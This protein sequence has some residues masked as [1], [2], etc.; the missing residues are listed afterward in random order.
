MTR[1]DPAS[2]SPSN[3]PAPTPAERAALDAARERAIKL[4]TD[5][6]ADDT[7]TVEEFE[8]RLDRMYQAATPAELDA[9]MGD[10]V[11]G[12]VR[13]AGAPGVVPQPAG[14]ARPYPAPGETPALRRML[15]VM[16][17]TKQGGYWIVPRRL[18]V[19]AFMGEVF[20]DLRDAALPPGFCE[21][22]VVAI[23]ANVKVLVPPGVIVEG[24][25]TS[26]M[27][28]FGNDAEDDGRLPG[29]ALRVRLTGLAL[30]AEVRVRVA[31]PGEPAKRAWRQAR[32]RDR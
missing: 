8:V 3:L 29:S 4:L 31:P 24:L 14:G 17:E 21:I 1:P 25:L 20:L 6:F 26:I 19:F 27:A 16:S 30:M 32:H 10:L 5:R 23:M 22:E 28:A 15:A 9:L 2:P 18:D 12:G 11:S 13:P 7:L